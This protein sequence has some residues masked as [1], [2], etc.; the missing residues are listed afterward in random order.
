M[1]KPSALETMKREMRKRQ[2]AQASCVSKYG[3]IYPHCWEKH[4]ILTKE[5]KEYK[6][7]IETF[8]RLMDE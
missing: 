5:I 7:S 8:E 3:L 1:T 6:E 4:K 2:E